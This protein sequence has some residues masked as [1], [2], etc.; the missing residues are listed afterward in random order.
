MK[1]HFE[2]RGNPGS[3]ALLLIHGFL[4]SNAQWLLNVDALAESFHVTMVE[5]CGHGRSTLPEGPLTVQRYLSTFEEIR[6]AL[7]IDSWG[8]IGQSYAAGLAIRYSIASPNRVTALMITNSRSALGNISDHGPR[9]SERPLADV[10]A[11]N[12]HLPIHPIYARRIPEPARSA[13]IEAADG[14][15]QA[16]IELGGSLGK[17]L[18]ALDLLPSI[19]C[20]FVIANGVYEKSFQ[21]DIS[22]LRTGTDIGIVDLP[23]G[24]AVNIEAA[25]EFN[26]LAKTFFSDGR[27]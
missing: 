21:K 6:E 18:N 12:R 27:R 26:E 17:E 22:H 15:S 14:V 1:L 9:R 13:L 4:S 16:A 25:T 10:R 20:P 19:P 11:D 24:H 8:L 5:L 3:P 2:S 23:A 7:N